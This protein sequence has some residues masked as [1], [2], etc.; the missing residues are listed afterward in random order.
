MPGVLHIGRS[1]VVRI[2]LATLSTVGI[3]VLIT[4]K[5]YS[6]NEIVLCLGKEQRYRRSDRYNYIK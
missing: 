1:T 5:L 2:A 4:N 6:E 3:N